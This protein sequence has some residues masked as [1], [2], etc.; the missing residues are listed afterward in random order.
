MNAILKYIL[1]NGVR[2]RLYIGLFV[3]LIITFGVSVFL[4][5]TMLVEQQATTVV[6]IAGSS[7][8]ILAVGM[9]LFVCIS[10]NRAFENKEVEFILS[11]AISRQQFVLAYLIGFFVTSLLIFIPLAIAIFL[12][13]NADKIADKIGI[14]IW[15]ITLLLENFL[16]IIFAL[17]V[18]L[19]LKN[20]FSAIMASFAFYIIARLMGMFVMAIKLPEDIALMKN[21]FLAIILKF[22]SVLFPRLDLFAQSSW[23]IYG[24]KDYSH[25]S[26]ILLQ[27][28]IYFLLLIFMSFHD[29]KKKQF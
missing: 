3:S 6:F 18:S 8:V 21:N 29:F 27:F 12:I 20:S 22:F 2:D 24:F 25:L 26:I 23:L 10:I 7:R 16:V 9:I 11:K 19:I 15:L 4:G 13:S 5:S 28:F 1:K 14:I 17:L